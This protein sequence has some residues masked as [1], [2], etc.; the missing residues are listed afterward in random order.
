MVNFF[1][2]I[3]TLFTPLLI[4]IFILTGVFIIITK[5]IVGPLTRSYAA[6]FIAFG[7][8]GGIAGLIAGASQQPIVSGLLTSMLGI[9]SAFLT[10]LLSKDILEELR[11]IIPIALVLLLTASLGG[12]TIGGSYKNDQDEF[13]RLY[14]RRL[15]LYEKVDLEVCKEERI[16]LL[17][18][19]KLPENYQPV[20]C[21][22][23]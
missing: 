15:M 1:D 11:Q 18:G 22:S 2:L 13:E 23:F 8:L 10:Y 6:F 5:M 3:K 7:F 4:T 17:R 16:L 9:I 12:L 14:K 19:Q 21:P 20:S